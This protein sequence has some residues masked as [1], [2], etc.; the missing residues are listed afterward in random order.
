MHY[1]SL[2]F[3]GVCCL[4]LAMASEAQEIVVI[5]QAGSPLEIIEYSAKYIE[6]GRYATEGVNHSVSLRNTGVQNVDAYTVSF[7]SFDF[8]NK[9]MGRGLG[10]ISIETIMPNTTAKGS[11]TQKP[12][13]A[14]SFDKYGTG[15]AYIS[16]VRLGDGTIWSADQKYVLSQMQKIQDDL[17]ADIFENKEE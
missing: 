5:Q 7:R 4:S 13:A 12:Y 14:F 3:V 16:S 9:D 6:G 8:F 2:G 15:V 11:W 17:T 1:I 10:G